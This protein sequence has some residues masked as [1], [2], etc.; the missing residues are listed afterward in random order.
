MADDRHFEKSLNRHNSA[1]VQQI[2]MKFG[3]R[4]I[5]TLSSLHTIII[6]IF[7]KSKMAD[8]CRFEKSIAVSKHRFDRSLRTFV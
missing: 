2:A 4:H 7:L 6:L 8:G 3:T 1:T 5:S